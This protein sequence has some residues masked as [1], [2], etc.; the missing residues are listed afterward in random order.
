MIS[1]EWKLLENFIFKWNRGSQRAAAWQ[2]ETLPETPDDETTCVLTICPHVYL[3]FSKCLSVCLSY[4]LCLLW[5]FSQSLSAEKHEY[6]Q[7][8]WNLMDSEWTSEVTPFI[9]KYSLCVLGI[10]QS[11]DVHIWCLSPIPKTVKQI[12]LGFGHFPRKD[13]EL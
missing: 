4:F 7:S 2:Y 1:R 8:L 11:S 5:I 10:G 6:M 13:N 12:S 9:F 3:G